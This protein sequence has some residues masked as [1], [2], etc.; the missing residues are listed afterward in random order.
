MLVA[1]Q[2][3]RPVAAGGGIPWTPLILLL[4]LGGGGAGLYVL[5]TK[6][7]AAPPAFATA[8]PIAVPDST[9]SYAT[10]AFAPPTPAAAA[11]APPPGPGGL[12]EQLFAQQRE[13][14]QTR[15]NDALDEVT[16]A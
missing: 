10:H 8:P 15:Y 5:R 4:L 7:A 14:Y 16:Q 9:P 6:K 2:L 1:T 13:K 3:P 11:A 12:K